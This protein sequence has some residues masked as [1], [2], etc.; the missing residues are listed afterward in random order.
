[1]KN[2]FLSIL[3][4]GLML[5]SVSQIKAMDPS[6]YFNAALD[7]GDR[8]LNQND[9]R[10]S[11]VAGARDLNGATVLKIMLQPKGELRGDIRPYRTMTKLSTVPLVKPRENETIADYLVRFERQRSLLIHKYASRIIR[12][13]QNLTQEE[14]ITDL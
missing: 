9:Q 1:M 5:G 6:A 4:A 8:E 14:S 2:Q 12:F 3:A 10:Q 13:E 11:I 7:S